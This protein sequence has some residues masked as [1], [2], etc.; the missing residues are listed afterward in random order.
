MSNFNI[1]SVRLLDEQKVD[2]LIIFAA[3]GRRVASWLEQ[4]TVSKAVDLVLI[5]STLLGHNA[6]A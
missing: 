1:L 5:R 2:P 3:F 6:G 4:R